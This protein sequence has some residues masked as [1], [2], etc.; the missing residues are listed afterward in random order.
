MGA[1]LKKSIDFEK[2]I[3]KVSRLLYIWSVCRN[4]PEILCHD[5]EIVME[6]FRA[7]SKPDVAFSPEITILLKK[8]IHSEQL[9]IQS[10]KL[11]RVTL[12]IFDNPHQRE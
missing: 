6:N 4:F 7:F 1:E 10:R 8:T 3:V 12:E 9:F 2:T 5:R 11:K